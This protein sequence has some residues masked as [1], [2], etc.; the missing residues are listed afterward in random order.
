MLFR[1]KWLAA[2]G[3][4]HEQ[5]VGVVKNTITDGEVYDWV[6]K[7]VK[8]TPEQKAAHWNDVLSRPLENDEAAK[9]RFQKR[10]EES[11]ITHRTEIKTFVD[12]MDADEKRI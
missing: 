7:N 9:A 10:M 1:S 12:Y 5:F 4:T 11:H 2:A 8:R 3:V 6:H